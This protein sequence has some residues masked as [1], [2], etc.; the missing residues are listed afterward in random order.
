MQQSGW[1]F[2]VDRG[3]TFTDFVAI[4]PRGQLHVHKMLSAQHG[5]RDV[6]AA[7][8]QAISG[9]MHCHELRIGTTLATNAL[10]ERKGARCALLVTQGWSD[11]LE[12]KYQNRPDIYSLSPHKT[13]PLYEAVGEATE[14]IDA[15]GKVLTA[16]DTEA[17]REKLAR[18]YALGIKALAVSF[19]HSY[20]NPQHELA[21]EKIAKTLGFTTIAL[22]HQVSPRIR[23]IARTETTTIAASLTPHLKLYTQ[24]L[25][26]VIAADKLLF[27]A[28]I[29]W[30]VPCQ[31]LSWQQCAVIG[32]S[33]WCRRCGENLCYAWN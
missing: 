33:R 19:L 24:Q 15:E 3:G 25:Q 9:E 14:R 17:V 26:E 12:I 22:S 11:A 2:W 8:M 23:Y 21:V 27:I 7:G 4:S 28:I 13:T 32:A 18:W 20:R 1:S 5:D 6:V 10:L 16:I 29:R 30:F 31:R